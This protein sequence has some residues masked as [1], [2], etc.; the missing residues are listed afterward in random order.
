MSQQNPA[1]PTPSMANTTPTTATPPTEH[2][3]VADAFRGRCSFRGET[4]PDP[5]PA[6]PMGLLMQ[7][8]GDAAASKSQP[9]PNAV[10][11]ATVDTDGRPSAR[12]VLA[13]HIDAAGGFVVFYTNYESRKGRALLAHPR[14]SLSFHWDHLDR[15]VRIE[16]PVTRSPEAE[17]D[18]YFAG[19]PLGSRLGAWAS[20]QSAPLSDR[21]DLL[22]ATHE[23]MQ[24]FGVSVDVDLEHD[25]DIRI[26]RPPHWGG[27]RVWI[28]R[29]ELWLGDPHRLHDRAEW[30]R[31]LNPGTVDGAAGYVAAGAWRAQRLQP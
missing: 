4:L 19:R 17:S 15:Q 11:L 25:R 26:P 2:H 29:V 21:A 3:G 13:R 6:E 14:A 10:T 31:G 28:E 22:I 20:R 24:K 16:G 18:A 9:N 12:V 1:N 30:T 7:W 23:S 27:F 8:V 5:L